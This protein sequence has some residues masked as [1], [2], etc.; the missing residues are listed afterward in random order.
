MNTKYFLTPIIEARTQ[1]GEQVRVW[2][3]VEGVH[4]YVPV[5]VHNSSIKLA[6]FSNFPRMFL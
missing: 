3:G 4:F 6:V 5:A 2:I 1:S